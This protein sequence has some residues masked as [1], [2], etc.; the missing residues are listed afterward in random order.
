SACDQGEIFET[1]MQKSE[2]EAEKVAEFYDYIEVQPPANYKNLV[3]RGLVQ[4]EA[5]LM[6]II[7]KITSLG[8][9]LNKLVV[10][11]GNVHYIEE[12]DQ[13]YRQ[14][15]IASQKGN[16]LNRQ[17]LPDT[18]FR[19]TNEMLLCFEF[20]GETLAQEIVVTNSNK[21][22]DSIENVFPL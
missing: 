2:D 20:L 21:L 1:M 12:H 19:T 13:L 10:G 8:K 22:N 16:P 7:K 6:D 5:Q 3:S 17:T 15:L 9:R 18:H 4:N 14:I 11:T